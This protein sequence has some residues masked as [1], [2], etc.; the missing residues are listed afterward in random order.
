[1]PWLMTRSSGAVSGRSSAL[2]IPAVT[3]RVYP[4]G[5]PIATTESPTRIVSES[6]HWSG[7]SARELASTWRTPMSV[8]GSVPTIFAFSLSPPEK[9]ETD[10]EV[11]FEAALA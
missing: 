9:L 10:P 4:K 5:L 1:M 2:T 3:D 11:P 7:V 6:P 8:D